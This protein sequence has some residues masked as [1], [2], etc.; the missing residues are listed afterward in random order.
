MQALVR[1]CAACTLVSAAPALLQQVRRP[2]PKGLLMC[3]ASS[4][5]SFYLFSYQVHEKSILLPLLPLTLLAPE[6]PGLAAWMPAMA[7]FSMFPLLK[8]DELVCAYLGCMILWA[9]IAWPGGGGEGGRKREEGQGWHWGRASILAVACCIAALAL[10]LAAVLV[11]PP[12]HLP[13]IIDALITAVCFL[14]FLSAAAYVQLLQWRE[15]P[16]KVKAA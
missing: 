2:S 11:T 14:H 13:Y 3:M 10:H 8:K 7:A 1:L 12:K 16:F 9:S 6:L 5:F 15:P 4:A